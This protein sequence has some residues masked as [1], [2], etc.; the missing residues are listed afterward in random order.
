MHIASLLIEN[1]S[2]LEVERRLLEKKTLPYPAADKF[3]NPVTKSCRLGGDTC[4]VYRAQCSRELSCCFCECR[5]HT[6]NFLSTVK[7]CLNTFSLNND[8]DVKC[9]F[10]LEPSGNS[11]VPTFTSYTDFL[12]RSMRLRIRRESLYNALVKGKCRVSSVSY[13]D[14]QGRNRKMFENKCSEFFS[15]DK[16]LDRDG[17][18]DHV[19][20]WKW[21]TSPSVYWQ[22]LRG[23]LVRLNIKCTGVSSHPNTCLLFK[24]GGLYNDDLVYNEVKSPRVCPGRKI[25]SSTMRPKST[26]ATT[27]VDV[28]TQ[29]STQ[30]NY[31]STVIELFTPNASLVKSTDSPL[32]AIRPPATLRYLETTVPN[33]KKPF[34]KVYSSADVTT[35]TEPRDDD[36][37][38]KAKVSVNAPR[39]KK[40]GMNWLVTGLIITVAVLLVILAASL[41][42]LFRKKCK[43]R[44]QRNSGEFAMNVVYHEAVTGPQHEDESPPLKP[45]GDDNY[46]LCYNDGNL[47]ESI[48]N[49]NVKCASAAT[50]DYA[51]NDADATKVKLPKRN[52][53]KQ[54]PIRVTRP[55]R[56]EYAVANRPKLEHIYNT[57]V[58][59]EYA[60]M[61]LAAKDVCKI[62]A[63]Y[64]NLSESE[65]TCRD[66]ATEVPASAEYEEMGLGTPPESG[67]VV[68]ENYLEPKTLSKGD[69]SA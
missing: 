31:S 51:Y 32:S 15:I 1:S 42:V 12:V 7:G 26:K 40:G 63:G 2:C 36:E 48:D 13:I 20:R 64:E 23:K 24:V 53:S 69:A 9:Y 50:Y 61:S 17:E 65:K 34:T 57:P 25:H 10:T 14:S 54:K 3:M 28:R 60:D 46:W 68:A 55:K 58:V 52:F 39:K 27:T 21:K 16:K 5:G 49:L 11:F 8:N 35:V 66:T 41:S 19:I 29:K 4:G 33:T 30:T 67:L 22:R 44:A 6:P 45:E 62:Q 59:E 38:E 18:I 56:N 43:K 47:Y 37:G